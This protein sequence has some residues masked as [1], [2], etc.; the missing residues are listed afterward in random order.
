MYTFTNAAAWSSCIT[1]KWQHVC[2]CSRY[3]NQYIPLL[4]KMK[5]PKLIRPSSSCLLPVCQS[6]QNS[7]WALGRVT[8]MFKCQRKSQ[9][10]TCICTKVPY[11]PESQ[12]DPFLVGLCAPKPLYLRDPA[13]FVSCQLSFFILFI[14]RLSEMLLLNQNIVFLMTW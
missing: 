9:I 12:K 8:F 2:K 13:V 4:C 14:F 11:L 5:G 1:H 3:K 7:S 6:H 10:P